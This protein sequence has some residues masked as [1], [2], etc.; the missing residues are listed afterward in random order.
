MPTLAAY[1]R[2]VHSQYGED[3]VVQELVRR[4]GIV[5]GQFV[6]FG[7][8]DGEHLSN[9]RLLLEQG[10]RGV[11]IEADPERHARLVTNM[12]PF[13]DRVV[14]LRAF[15][16]PEGEQSLD[17]LLK[18][19]PTES[20]FDLL[21]I[22]IDSFDWHIWRGLKQYRP[23]IVIIE[24]NSS[25]PVGIIKTNRALGDGGSSFSA[26]LELGN[27]KGY[28]L[29]CHTIANMIF[30]RSDMVSKLG[31]PDDELAY[32]ETLCDYAAVHVVWDLYLPQR[33]I[34]LWRRLQKA[35]E[36]PRRSS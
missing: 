10:W 11:Y 34:R 33:L 2:N 22:D 32:P 36:R 1:R 31:L 7:A 20:S 12:L 15:V 21:S 9:T 14:S 8:W 5:N 16:E 18:Q 13:K 27:R 29:V 24:I 17:Q 6:E 35:A 23:T 4:L 3:G 25:I 26:T 30:V 28:T 19:T